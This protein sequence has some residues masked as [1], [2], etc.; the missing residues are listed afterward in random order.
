MI[1]KLLSL[2][3]SPSIQ[4]KWEAY[5]FRYAP[6]NTESKSYAWIFE[7]CKSTSSNL[8]TLEEPLAKIGGNIAPCLGVPQVV[9]DK[10]FKR[11]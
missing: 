9:I 2:P 5:I 6:S 1:I 4:P 3:C 8:T 10:A 7:Y 11:I